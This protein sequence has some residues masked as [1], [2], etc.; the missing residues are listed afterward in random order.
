MAC[1][2]GVLVAGCNTSPICEIELE[3]KTGNPIALLPLRVYLTS[4]YNMHEEQRSKFARALALTKKKS[5]VQ[6][7]GAYQMIRSV[8]YLKPYFSAK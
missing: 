7:N 2:R 8:F 6:K 3:L 5:Y 4:K 1:D